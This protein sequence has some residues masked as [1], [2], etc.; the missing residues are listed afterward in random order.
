MNK[1][2]FIDESGDPGTD[3][4][5]GASKSFT[6]VAILFDDI[7]EMETVSL[8]IKKLSRKLFKNDY[9][10]FHFVHEK[11]IHRLEFFKLIS[12]FNFKI[13]V[14][15]TDKSSDISIGNI[16]KKS[17]KEICNKIQDDKFIYSFKFDGTVSKS[18]KFGVEKELRLLAKNNFL[19]NKIKF[20]NSK[21][22]SLI[23]LADMCAGVI[24][25]KQEENTLNTNEM[26]MHIKGKI[27]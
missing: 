15:L 20:S 2:L 6:M 10:E 26:Y 5:N 24:R 23:Q 9:H 27:E 13:L 19:I 4:N 7:L 11:N 14:S 17:L 8:E 3:I 12:S 25:R 16:Y 1:Y 22:D 18:Y 21:N